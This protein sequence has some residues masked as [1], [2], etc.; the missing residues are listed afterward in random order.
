[1]VD[2]KDAYRAVPIHASCFPLTGLSWR[3]ANQDTP[4]YIYDARLPF[5]AAKSCR[6]FQSLTDR[7]VHMM[8]GRN[9]KVRG[10]LDDFLCVEDTVELCQASFE[11]L[12]EL[13]VNLGFTI[14]PKKVEGPARIM[15]FLGVSIDC[16]NRTLSL[17]S[18]K[19]I[20]MK[21]LCKQWLKKRKCTKRDLQSIIG[22][23]NWCGRVLKG[24]RTFTRRLINL[25][26]RVP[27][28]GHHIRIPAEARAD[29]EWWC[30]ALQYFHSTVKFPDDI[31][32]PSF[33]FA[34]DACQTGGGGHFGHDWFFTAWG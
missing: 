23:M 15:T 22:K 18:D 6:I 25:L 29:I 14:N 1:M 5:G 8:A 30:H 24:G 32:L 9:F 20:I 27:L 26:C 12:K 7:I 17:P 11:C 19:L 31:P 10:Y 34:T 4:T 33:V 3:F 21:L 13:L 16:I 2:L 28:A